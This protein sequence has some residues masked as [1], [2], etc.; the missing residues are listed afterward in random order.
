MKESVYTYHTVKSMKNAIKLIRSFHYYE[1]PFGKHC[2]G[3]R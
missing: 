2:G 3:I 1:F